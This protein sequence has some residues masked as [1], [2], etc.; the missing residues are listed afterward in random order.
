MKKDKYIC[1]LCSSN[2]FEKIINY[3]F[4]NE[5]FRDKYIVECKSCG[6]KSIYPNI[7]EEQLNNY[8][9][10]YYLN[11]HKDLKLD[12]L[13]ETFFCNIAKCRFNFLEK[14]LKKE[15]LIIKNVLE[16]GPGR[17]HFY[18]QF[19]KNNNNV[20]YSILESDINYKKNFSKKNITIYENFEEILKNDFDLI[21]FS[22][23]L[24]HIMKPNN[25]LK[26]IY[27]IL[28]TKGV[29][30]LEVPCLDYLYKDIFEP[31]VFFYSKETLSL[32]LKKNNFQNH[33]IFYFGK[34]ISKL[35]SNKFYNKLKSKFLTILLKFNLTFMIK[36]K[37]EN[38]YDFLDTK[39]EKIIADM[40]EMN[41]EH[42][43]PSWW[44]R[45]LIVKN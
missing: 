45:A 15:K 23:V 29:I 44:M 14:F 2:E 28:K 39:Y 3:K 32:L 18:E 17:G 42:Y 5:I 38:N 25:F 36:I 11:A 33:Q 34:N 19:A 16:I 7:H 4:I 43:K 13:A 24:E 12:K 8:N 40:Y 20:N 6:I 31:H 35:Q 37:E 1:E 26:K 41:S 22:H 9:N 30:F 10:N 21:I 27:K